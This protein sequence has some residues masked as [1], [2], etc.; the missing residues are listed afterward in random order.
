MP[1]NKSSSMLS[2]N[3]LFELINTLHSGNDKILNNLINSY[4]SLTSGISSYDKQRVNSIS[5]LTA[6]KYLLCTT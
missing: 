6:L 2:P 1:L 3:Y 4:S 5:L